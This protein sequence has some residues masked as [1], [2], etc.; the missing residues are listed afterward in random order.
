MELRTLFDLARAYGYDDWLAFDASLV[1]GLAYYTG[2]VFEAFDRG[3]NLRAICGGGR[4]DRL[5]STFGG[6]DLPACGFGF[7]DMVL[8]EFLSEQGL[9]PEPDPG[10]DDVVFAFEENLREA[11]VEVATRLRASGRRV[12]LV[13]EPRKVKWAYR[14]ANRLGASRVVL[15][16]PEEHARGVVRIK[17]LAS[18]EESD[19]TLTDLAPDP[20]TP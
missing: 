11:A 5:L 14:H 4:Y 16:A 20:D 17:D 3:G 1:R 19:L 13:L 8:L 18:G 2:I 12:D 7:G 15:V 10:I 9:L 6:K